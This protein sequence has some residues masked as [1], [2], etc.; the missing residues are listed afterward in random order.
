MALRAMLVCVA[1]LPVIATAADSSRAAHKVTPIQKVLQMM[2]ELKTKAQEEKKGEIQTFNQFTTFCKNTLRDKGYAIKDGT[3]SMS[4]LSADIEDYK[5]KAAVL[6]REI[7]TLDEANDEHE[8]EKAEAK[9][10]REK[11]HRDH[12]V[13][14]SD[15]QASLEDMAVGI[16]NLKKMMGSV[17]ASSF[18]QQMASKPHL[19]SSARKV[20]ASF[21]ATRSGLDEEQPDAQAFEGQS[22][23]TIGMMNDLSSKMAEEK[24]D[25]EKEEMNAQH[26]YEMLVQ[27]FD[28][29][30]ASDTELRTNKAIT[31]KQME[32]KSAG[33][34][35]DL[36]DAKRTKAEDEKYSA[37]LT[38]MCEEKSS[39]FESRQ[40]VRAEELEAIDKAMEIIGGK[41]VA[42][43]GTKHLPELVQTKKLH[44]SLSQLRSNVQKPGQSAAAS[45]LQA[46]G[47]MLQS[48]VLSALA[49]HMSA[50][51][52]VKVRKMISNMLLKLEQEANEEAEHK[53]WCDAEMGSNQQTRD[54]KTT[55]VEM[56][57]AQIDELNAA[58]QK[59]TTEIADQTQEISE[60]DAA[61]AEATQIRQA[62]K[63]KNTATIAD[64]G[65]AV[66]A[67]EQATK[68][69]RN[70][71]AKASSATAFVQGRAKKGPADEV[72]GT[73]DEPFTGSGGEGGVLGMLEVILSDFQRLESETT[74]NED[75]AAQEYEKF[76]ADSA[77]DRE[78]KRKSSY[79]KGNEKSSVE[80]DTHL[81]KKDLAVTQKE[82]NA[83]QE[84]YEKLKP[85]CVDA[86]VSYA[87]RVKQREEEIDSLKEALTIMEGNE[88]A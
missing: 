25:L 24:L 44:V 52:F 12:Q 17:A 38:V 60:I 57:T 59:L 87:D 83:A 62:E 6:G 77:D 66:G 53:G 10:V 65:S 54:S 13:T 21:L 81:A 4:K 7:R 69:L 37:D 82:L 61:V 8:H 5:A 80:H 30:I 42:G 71:Y 74:A 39:D 55:K 41:S 23:P 72:P 29:Q 75:A 67:V 51:P 47:R 35:S 64:A 84:Y 20:L 18:I 70:F 36:G 43:A 45:F 15:Y 86:G 76:S 68:V 49:A 2:A 16:Q 56:L 32:Q 26:A 22:D 88:V 33:A 28:N 19:P 46:Q 50:D 1:L 85:S 3:A 14:H 27:S 58:N 34:Q 40:K 63:A 9:E 79:H 31:M 48:R 73:W 78:S 11:A